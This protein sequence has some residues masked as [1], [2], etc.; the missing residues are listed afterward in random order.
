MQTAN[1]IMEADKRATEKVNTLTPLLLESTPDVLSVG[2]RCMTE[3]YSF[4]WEK[5]ENPYFIDK[6]G[7]RIDLSVERYIPYLNDVPEKATP[8]KVHSGFLGEPEDD[9]MS[10]QTLKVTPDVQVSDPEHG[11]VTP[12]DDIIE[13]DIAQTGRARKSLVDE[14]RSLAHQLTH[15]PKSPYCHTCARGK[16]TSM[17]S[18]RTSGSELYKSAKKFG[19]VVTVDHA[20]AQ[21]KMDHGIDNEVAMVV[22]LDVYT[23]WL[24]C[25]PVM[26]K[27]ADEVCNALRDICGPQL[28]IKTMYSDNAP[29]LV[30]AAYEKAWVHERALPGISRNNGLVERMVRHIQEGT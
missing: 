24:Q 21:S 18:P 11:D 16:A 6:K 20:I 1:G 4:H 26:T 7:R 23:G 17:R 30:Q 13:A 15:L 2:R 12:E 8:A 25:Y 29:E 9:L 3:G 28:V 10:D 27:D 22:I 14:A 5:G 19:D